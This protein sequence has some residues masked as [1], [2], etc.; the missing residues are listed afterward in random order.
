MGLSSASAKLALAVIAVSVVTFGLNLQLWLSLVPGMTL[1][2]LALWQPLTYVFLGSSP[3]EVLFS[4]L[5]IWQMGGYF[6][7]TWGAR[8]L[9][10]Y[11]VGLAALAGV[12]TVLTSLLIPSLRTYPFGG[13]GVIA[14]LLWIG[15]GLSYGKAQLSFWGAPVSGYAFAGI[16]GLFVVLQAA[17]GGIVS[18]IPDV[19]AIAM[20]AAYIRLGSPRVWWLRLQSWR[21]TRELKGRSKH[22]RIIQ[23]DDTTQRGDDRWLN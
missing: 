18:V 8:R 9:V 14:S 21:L 7:A 16:G 23:Q 13:A 6:E 11:S 17:F 2:S 4:A 12:L 3:M 1:G 10:T 15:Y 22:L 5:I 20:G 19:F